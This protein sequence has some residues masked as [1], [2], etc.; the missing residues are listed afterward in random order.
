MTSW[1]D[2]SRGVASGRIVPQVAAVIDGA[3]VFVL[4]A[5]GD[6]ELATLVDG[7]ETTL[8]QSVDLTD[9]DLVGAT[10]Q[11]VGV[12]MQSFVADSGLTPGVALWAMDSNWA[13]AE[14]SVQ[15][16]PSLLAVGSVAVGAETYSH[17]GGRCR[18]I[19][20]GTADSLLG[21]VNAPRLFTATIAAYTV[22]AW[23]RFDADAL[24]TSHWQ[25]PTVFAITSTGAGFRAYLVGE[26]GIGTP[27]RWWPSLMNYNGGTTTYTTF[28]AYPIT[29][30]N[31]WHLFSWVY[32]SALAGT[33]RARLY[34]DGAFVANGDITLTTA[35]AA[36]TI[37]GTIVI[38]D[39]TLAGSIG[40]VSIDHVAHDATRVLAEYHRCVDA[41]LAMPAAW[42]MQVLVDGVVYCDR[43]VIA[44][45]QR[46]WTDFLAPVRRLT[47][48]HTVTFR[49]RIEEA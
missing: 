38:G 46:R 6:T 13:N 14:N 31:G 3:N 43:V 36:P 41:P 35:P 17:G 21:G 15:P 19:P 40:Q 45:E 16:G 23:V 20:A 48:T 33:A 25:A 18:V 27:H 7:D 37:A 44:A 10:L 9:V 4:G 22:H 47:G 29:A 5:E 42:R 1:F 2:R 8:S 32:D 49:L 34:V 24:P 30:T 26:S 12:A 11:T 28:L 39:P